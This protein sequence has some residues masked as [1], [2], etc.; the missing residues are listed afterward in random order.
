[1]YNSN[2]IGFSSC[3]VAFP[4]LLAELLSGLAAEGKTEE[5]IIYLQPDRAERTVTDERLSSQRVK[6][7]GL[8][9]MEG[10]I[11]GSVCCTVQWC[12]YFCRLRVNNNRTFRG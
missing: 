1:M 8:Q 3:D 4:P 5:T 7:G 9:Q 10:Y 6:M 11:A 2:D 12:T